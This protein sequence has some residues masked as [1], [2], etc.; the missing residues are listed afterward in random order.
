MCFVFDLK[1]KIGA[2]ADALKLFEVNKITNFMLTWH[3]F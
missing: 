2:L 1:E 3:F